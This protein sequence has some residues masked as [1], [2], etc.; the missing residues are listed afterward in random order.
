MRQPDLTVTHA[1]TTV[2][3]TSSHSR[4]FVLRGRSGDGPGWVCSFGPQAELEGASVR[5]D[6]LLLSY[7]PH[8]GVLLPGHGDLVVTVRVALTTPGGGADGVTLQLSAPEGYPLDELAG[9]LVTPEPDGSR[10]DDW[11][12]LVPDGDGLWLAAD[13]SGPGARSRVV[14]HQHR[15]SLPMTAV[16]DAAGA[17]G[18]AATSSRTA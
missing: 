8:A 7:R 17:A 10:A 14:F 5:G 16:V 12:Y 15:I 1:G 2:R 18:T 13:G 6:G 4:H 3:L 11:R 9:P